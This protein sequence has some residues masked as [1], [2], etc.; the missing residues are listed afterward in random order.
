MLRESIWDQLI[1]RTSRTSTSLGFTQTRLAMVELLFGCVPPFVLSRLRTQFLRA[2][3]LQIGKSTQFFGLPRLVGTGELVRRIHV[4]E[5]CGINAGSFFDLTEMIT[6]GDHV[7]IG[8]DAM[9][10]SRSEP[11][12]NVGQLAE[13]RLQAPIKIGNGVWLGARCTIMPG[14][15]VGAGSVIGA[16]IVVSNNVP[17]NT[18]L[19]G[20]QAISLARWR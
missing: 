18:L 14:V 13:P 15:T 5:H 2:A 8:H 7:A 11:N 12:G 9:F 6:I 20:A 10:L 4:G 1:D 16:G 17:E 19:T 3:G